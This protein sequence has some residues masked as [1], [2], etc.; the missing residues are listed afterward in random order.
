M[1]SKPHRRRR[2]QEDDEEDG[3]DADDDGEEEEADDEAGLT[4]HS[5]SSRR[6]QGKIS[7]QEKE[8]LAEKPWALRGEVHSH[9]RPQNR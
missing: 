1:A 5:A 8:L 3:T 6:M 2:D 7:D 4:G 9:D